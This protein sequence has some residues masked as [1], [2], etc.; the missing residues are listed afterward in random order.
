L[1]LYDRYSGGGVAT[2]RYLVEGKVQG[3]GFRYFALKEAETLGVAGFARNLPDGRV[4][5]VAEAAEE[6]LS[7][8]EARLR[9]GPAFA[10]VSGLSRSTLRP[11]GATGFDIR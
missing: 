6:V 5:V 10:R 3:V 2:Y 7:D 11:R 1:S 9:E 4:E 8:F